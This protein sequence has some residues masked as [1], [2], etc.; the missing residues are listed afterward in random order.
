MCCAACLSYRIVYCV[1]YKVQFTAS[2]F[3]HLHQNTPKL[4]LVFYWVGQ[5]SK[6]VVHQCRING[7]ISNMTF[8]QDHINSKFW[9][10]PKYLKLSKWI[11]W[12][13]NLKFESIVMTTMKLFLLQIYYF[14]FSLYLE[15][16]RLDL[17]KRSSTPIVCHDYCNSRKKVVP[18]LASKKNIGNSS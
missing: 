12:I 7:S 6:F 4:V 16:W 11:F 14:A 10:H 15:Q 1:F 2:I 5:L 17:G 18:M 13:H 3:F 8:T 9:F